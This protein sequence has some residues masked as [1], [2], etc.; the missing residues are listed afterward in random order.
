ML[1]SAML[2]SVLDCSGG[3]MGGETGLLSSGDCEA[4]CRPPPPRLRHD[5]D[6]E[7]R[8]V[9]AQQRVLD[10]TFEDGGEGG[11]AQAPRQPPL[12]PQSPRTMSSSSGA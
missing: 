1:S 6:A 4:A 5:V 3:R 2:F 10:L 12:P 8:E 9:R 11:V 7:A